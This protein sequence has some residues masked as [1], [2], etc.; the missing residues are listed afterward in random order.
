MG[1]RSYF[2][3]VFNA[4]GLWLMGFREI[5][6]WFLVMLQTEL[7]FPVWVGSLSLGRLSL[8]PLSFRAVCG[9]TV[10]R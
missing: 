9:V 7:G 4:V 6:E 5:E 3:R 10:C 8:F 1:M 2:K